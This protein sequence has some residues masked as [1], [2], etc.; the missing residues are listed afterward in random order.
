MIIQH[1]LSNRSNPSLLTKAVNMKQTKTI[2]GTKG[3]TQCA[4]KIWIIQSKV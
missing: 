2:T 4:H 3:K 1:G